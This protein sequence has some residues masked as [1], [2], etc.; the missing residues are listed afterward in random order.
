MGDRWRVGVLTLSD[1][2]SRGEREDLSGPLIAELL[3]GERF[4]VAASAVVPDEA[5]VITRTLVEWADAR[6]LSLIVTTG[7]TGVS[8]RDVTP[9]ATKKVLDYE[10]PGMA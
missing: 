10:L 3:G 9:Q 4:E 8:P 7:G 6:K 1:K 5:E 2:G